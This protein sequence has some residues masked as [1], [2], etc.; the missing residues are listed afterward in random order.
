[1]AGLMV[2]IAIDL[3]REEQVYRTG[4]DAGSTWIMASAHASDSWH[5]WSGGRG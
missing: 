1:V 2:A 3:F 4:F 5:N